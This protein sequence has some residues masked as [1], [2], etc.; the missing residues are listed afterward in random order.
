MV[1]FF[2]VGNYTKRLINQLST[3]NENIGSKIINFIKSKGYNFSSKGHKTLTIEQLSKRILNK[4]SVEI[5]CRERGLLFAAISRNLTHEN[6]ILRRVFIKNGDYSDHYINQWNSKFADLNYLKG[7]VNKNIHRPRN[8]F[9][10]SWEAW[11]NIKD[12]ISYFKYKGGKEH[13]YNPST[14]KRNIPDIV[15]VVGNLLW[16]ALA[17]KDILPPF[18]YNV[19]LGRIFGFNFRKFERLVIHNPN[20]AIK[21]LDKYKNELNHISKIIQ[22]F[23]NGHS[24]TGSIE[25][26]ILNIHYKE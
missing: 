3:E 19:R 22:H 24:I 14:E 1:N 20:E 7:N 15:A 2:K 25:L 11:E 12:D 10:F 23:N 17:L 13:Y 21:Y 8:T 18:H 4:D 6:I 16:D 9:I 26:K 5:A